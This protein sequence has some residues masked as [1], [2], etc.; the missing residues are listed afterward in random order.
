MTRKTYEPK[1]TEIEDDVYLL[2]QRIKSRIKLKRRKSKDSKLKWKAYYKDRSTGAEAVMFENQ[3][4]GD[5][6]LKIKGGAHD[7]N[8]DIHNDLDAI[9]MFVILLRGAGFKVYKGERGGW[10]A[11]LGKRKHREKKIKC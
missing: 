6:I 4:Y 8:F 1:Q 5:L 10:R 11:Y 2:E 3:T 7:V 9:R